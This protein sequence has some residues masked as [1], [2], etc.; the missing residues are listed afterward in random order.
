ME[1]HYKHEVEVDPISPNL[2]IFVVCFTTCWARL[3]LYNALD[4]LQERVL[5]FDTDSVIF[6]SLPDEPDPRLSDF[7]GDF[8]DEID[9]GDYIVE[10]VSGG[11]KN[12]GYRTKK[13][14]Q[15]CKVCGLSLNSREIEQVNFGIV[16]QNVID[17]I[18]DPLTSGKQMSSSHITL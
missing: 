15:E 16:R 1:I 17:E 7:L 8:K 9:T 12:Y 18:K 10:Y 2:N 3:R 13:G 14:K 4:L 6:A 11:P 5:Y